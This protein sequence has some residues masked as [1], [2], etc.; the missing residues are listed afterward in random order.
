MQTTQ[1]Q[2]H[3]IS[4]E[5]VQGTNVYSANGDSVGSI[6][7][8]MIDKQSG[9]VAYAVMTFGGFLGLGESYYPVPWNTL[10]YDTS[11]GGYRT[12]ITEDQLRNAPAYDDSSWNDRDWERRTYD[13]Y[14]TPYYWGAGGTI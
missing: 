14:R 13:H 5:R 2:E 7:H 4:S 1:S 12:D 9:Q 6:D 8:V 11:L 10:K 3:L